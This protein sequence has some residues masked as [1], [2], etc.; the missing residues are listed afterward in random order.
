MSTSF[1]S[2]EWG[3]SLSETICPDVQTTVNLLGIHLREVS[4]DWECPSHKHDQYEINYVLQGTQQMKAG[5]H[6][7]TQQAGDVVI[8]PPGI[9]HTSRSVGDQSLVYVC[10]HF[11][12]NDRVFLSLLERLHQ[13]VFRKDSMAAQQV[14]PCIM[15]LVQAAEHESQHMITRRIRLQAASF[16]LFS[17][18]WEILLNEAAQVSPSTYAHMELAHQIAARLQGIVNRNPSQI[19]ERPDSHYGIDDIA[20]ELGISPSHCNRIFHQVFAIS[21]RSYLSNLVLHKSKLLLADPQM[22]IQ[23]IATTLG[24][25]DIAHFSRQFKR[26]SGISPSHYRKTHLQMRQPLE[27][28][29]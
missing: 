3:I 18:L 20:A 15:K 7:Y 26:W 21:P 28:G 6:S 13:L 27:A 12:M 25:R 23:D 14:Q 2:P 1:I 4:R 17:V 22:S 29:V 11:E 5:T 19:A 16:E 9:P 24:Y 10:I 8:L